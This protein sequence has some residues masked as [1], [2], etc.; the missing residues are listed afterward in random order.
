MVDGPS[1]EVRMRAHVVREKMLTKPKHNLVGHQ[2]EVGPM[3]FSPNGKLL[4]TGGADG[5]VILW[6]PLT[7][8]EVARFTVD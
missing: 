6:N 2:D 4:A 7:G 8:K 5:R 1:A 3:A